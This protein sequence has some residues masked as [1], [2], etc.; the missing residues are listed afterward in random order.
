MHNPQ[1]TAQPT[2]LLT[3]DDYARQ[4]RATAI[5]PK[6]IG[7][8]Y[9]ALGL[10][11]EGGELCNKIK[12]HYR[13]GKPFKEMGLDKELGDVLWYA[14]NLAYE[15]GYPLAAIAQE[16]LDKLASR[17]QRGTLG[18]SGDNR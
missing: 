3:F 2:Y 17:Q 16:N 5:Y 18:G 11:G 8:M 13:D 10:V 9:C 12:K 7:V 15:L 14:A 4:A 1:P 6:E